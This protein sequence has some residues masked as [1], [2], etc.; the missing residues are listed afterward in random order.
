M[1]NLHGHRTPEYKEVG[2]ECGVIIAYTPE[3]CTDLCAVNDYGLGAMVKGQMQKLYKQ[4]Y[5]EDPDAWT[6]AITASQR[7]ILFTKWLKEAWLIV[8]A[9]TE[10]IVTAFKRC[11][12][13]ND[14]SGS[15]DSEIHIRGYEEEY[16]VEPY[17]PCSD[18]ESESETDS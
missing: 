1:D 15:E 18:S 17:E 13:L 2:A 16:V 9:R 4:A 11:G 7:R 10:T 3:D 14:I 6:D 12:V 5:D 8:S